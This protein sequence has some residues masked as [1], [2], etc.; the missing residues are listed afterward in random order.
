MRGRGTARSEPISH[1]CIPAV[2]YGNKLARCKVTRAAISDGVFAKY[3]SRPVS[4]WKAEA[5]TGDV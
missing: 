5:Q 1:L 2:G 4:L 3:V